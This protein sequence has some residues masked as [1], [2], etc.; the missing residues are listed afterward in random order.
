MELSAPTGSGDEG[1]MAGVP[2]A[3]LQGWMM[4]L[5]V[6]PYGE[7]T[8]VTSDCGLSWGCWGRRIGG[9]ALSA[10]MGSSIVADCLSQPNSQADIRYGLTGVCHQTANRILHPAGITVAGCQGYGLSVFTFGT[11]GLGPWPQLSACYPAGTILAPGTTAMPQS[12][13]RNLLPRITVYNL[14]PST[15]TA[16]EVPPVAELRALIESAL[17]HPIEKATLK[18]LVTVQADLRRNQ[19]QITRWLG[20]A[21]RTAEQYLELVNTAVRS[22]IEHSP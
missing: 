5:I 2:S 20:S 1:T 6:A 15:T 18:G 16:Q 17:G 8:Y 21:E 13:A 22:A 11:Y 9:T 14:T 12:M 7:H 4:P 10:A 19:S 3:T